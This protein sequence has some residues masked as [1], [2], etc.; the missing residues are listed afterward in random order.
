MTDASEDRTAFDW[1]AR[2]VADDAPW[3]RQGLHPALS[4]WA[5]AG[6]IRPGLSV[7]VPGCGRSEE[8]A[9]LARQG[10]QV[11]GVDLAPTAIAWQTARFEREG[12]K[13]VFI[14]GDGLS[15]RSETPFDLLYEQTFLCAIHPHHRAAYAEMAHDVLRPGG[16]LLALFMQK[17]ERGGPPYGCDLDA[18]RALFPDPQWIWP[19]PETITPYPH[20]G[21]NDKAELGAVLI[22]R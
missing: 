17:A 10:L 7:L 22:R 4:D 21:L 6:L 3:E 2:F 1:E 14:T 16:R 11:T 8:P 13:G 19:E 15:W 12:L 20:P 5:G 9:A 18:M